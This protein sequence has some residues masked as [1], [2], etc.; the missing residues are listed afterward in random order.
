M[1]P[2]TLKGAVVELHTPAVVTSAADAQL[3]G[4][5]VLPA[6]D[7][8]AHDPCREAPRPETTKSL[9]SSVVLLAHCSRTACVLCY[10]LSV[11]CLRGSRLTVVHA[12]RR[13]CHTCSFIKKLSDATQHKVIDKIQSLCTK[14]ST[15]LMLITMLV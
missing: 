9:A 7:A 14:I 13:H 4:V 1:T 8:T 12:A 15:K 10:T 5:A 6:L 11:H 3:N 2:K